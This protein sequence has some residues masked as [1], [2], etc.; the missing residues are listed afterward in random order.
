MT[1][2]KILDRRFF[3]EGERIVTEGEEALTA[4]V[5]QSG[6]VR[7]FSEKKGKKVELAMLGMGDIFGET[8]LILGGE[9]TASAEAAENANI[10][11]VHRDD[12]YNKLRKS[13]PTIR[14]VVDMLSQRLTKSNQE[15]LK[16]KG[17]NIDSFIILLNQIF[18]DLMETMPEED[19][20]SFKDD[21]FPVMKD[22]IRVVEKYRDKL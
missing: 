18:V 15:V 14:A 12:F 21:A 11:V 20:K 19:Q 8:S 3:S 1:H 5:V 17:V 2:T 22:L 6:S 4:F 7:I 9:R 16:S 10:I 13:D